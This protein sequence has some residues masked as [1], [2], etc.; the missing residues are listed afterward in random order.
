MAFADAVIKSVSDTMSI[1]Q[2]FA[3]RSL[4]GL[5]IL[6]LLT[7]QTGLR[8][9]FRSPWVWLRSVLLVLC[10]LTYYASLPWLDL[11]LAAVAVYTNPVITTVLA[12]IW[13]RE[14]VS[15]R[16]LAGVGLGFIGVWVIIEPGSAEFSAAIGLPI[17]AAL[18]YSTAMITTRAKCRADDAL[19]MG[20]AL[21]IAFVVAGVVG[22]AAVHLGSFGNPTES[23]TLFLTRDWVDLSRAQWATLAILGLLA[24]AY[25]TGV[26]KAYQSA[27]PQRL[28]TFDYGYLISATL[29]G[30]VLFSEVPDQTTIIGMALI[31]AAGLLV[32]SKPE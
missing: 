17:L 19:A 13:L 27:P 6:L 24:A 32:A 11:S 25:F 4:F 20:T 12:A 7:H 10:W 26:A 16:Q 21:H 5:P 28:A 3:V 23:D 15:R 31:T 30:F 1:W 9:A 2:L 18:F 14:P 8:R 29:W 22:L